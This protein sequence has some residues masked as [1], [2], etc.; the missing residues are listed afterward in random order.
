MNKI[1]EKHYPVFELY[2]ALRDQLMENLDDTDLDFRPGGDNL[3]LG[4]LCVQM[5]EVEQSYIDS[6]RTFKQDFSY[7][8]ED[9]ALA[10]S[11]EQLQTWFREL[12]SELKSAVAA[13]SEDDIE[14]RVIDRGGEFQLR[15]HVQLEVYKEALL[16]FYGKVDVYLKAMGKARPEQWREW[17]G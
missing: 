10:N 2:Q 15:P 6:F 17:I 4:A 1:I 7:R 11:T 16:I 12:D 5:G 9:P 13:L 8:S 3:T 14:N